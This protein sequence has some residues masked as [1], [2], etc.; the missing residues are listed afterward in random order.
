[1]KKISN[2]Y[3]RNES[4]TEV[5][6]VDYNKLVYDI[7]SKDGVERRLLGSYLDRIQ[8]FLVRKG[9]VKVTVAT[10]NKIKDSHES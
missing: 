10:Y 8:E 3:F 4:S 7:H 6:E 5:I 9:W 2:K 1:M